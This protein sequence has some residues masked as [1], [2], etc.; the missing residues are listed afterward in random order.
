MIQKCIP[1]HK[2]TN[3]VLFWIIDRMTYPKEKIVFF[4]DLVLKV[5]FLVNGRHFFPHLSCLIDTAR[6][7]FSWALIIVFSWHY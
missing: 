6:D 4:K 7:P 1:S 2:A 5:L 3:M